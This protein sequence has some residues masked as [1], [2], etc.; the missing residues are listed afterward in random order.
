M[1]VRIVGMRCVWDNGGN[2]KSDSGTRIIQSQL[3]SNRFQIEVFFTVGDIGWKL[4]ENPFSPNLTKK[5][6]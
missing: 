3:L 5:M 2:M 6:K 1:R 4:M